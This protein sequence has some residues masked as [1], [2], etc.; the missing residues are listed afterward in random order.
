MPRLE[1]AAEPRPL[2]LPTVRRGRDVHCL[3]VRAVALALLLVARCGV[4]IPPA[5]ARS[6]RFSGAE[7]LLFRPLPGRARRQRSNRFA[8]NL[9][10]I[11]EHSVIKDINTKVYSVRGWVGVPK[12]KKQE[13]VEKR[14]IQIVLSDHPS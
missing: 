13:R 7:W 10:S 6:Q 4:L 12:R 1:G 2:P 3:V 11:E 14:P 8:G 9:N 5:G